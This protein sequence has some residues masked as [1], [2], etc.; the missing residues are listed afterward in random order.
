[1]ELMAWREESLQAEAVIDKWDL[2]GL[3][4]F[5]TGYGHL[6]EMLTGRLGYRL[7]VDLIEFAYD[8]RQDCR[9]S[10]VQLHNQIEAW[11]CEHNAFDTPVVVLAHS[12]GGLVARYWIEHLGG[13]AGVSH[14]V[15]FGSPLQGSPT[16]FE[17]LAQGPGFIPLHPLRRKLNDL[18]RTMPSLYQ[19]LPS[20]PFVYSGDGA[21]INIYEERAWLPERFHHLLENGQ[22]FHAELG[23]RSSVPTLCVAGDGIETPTRVEVDLSVAQCWKTM[24]LIREAVGD[25]LVPVSSAL[26]PGAPD[27]RCR[28][29]HEM[30]MSAEQVWQWLL[31]RLSSEAQRVAS[32]WREERLERAA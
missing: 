27:Y 32:P 1:M 4:R 14:L 28:Y 5:T 17:W 10:A 16:A 18:V 29:D 8:W 19:L 23:S 11:R 30:L 26:L 20:T 12:M 22:R 15:L 9:R 2:F 6:R 21:A 24:R 31:P 7:G 13:A 3:L 25:G